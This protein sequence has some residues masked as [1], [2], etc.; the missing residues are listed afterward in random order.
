MDILQ[1]VTDPNRR[2]AQVFAHDLGVALS[3]R[4]HQVATVALGGGTVA[5]L[6]LPFIHC[7]VP[8]TPVPLSTLEELLR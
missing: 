1:V 4:G 8:H 3:A 5:R 6:R 2:G 7:D